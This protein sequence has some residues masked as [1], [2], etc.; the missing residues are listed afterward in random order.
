MLNTPVL[1]LIFNRPDTTDR[2]FDAIRKAQPKQ[3]FVAADGPRFGNVTDV[4]LCNSTKQIID[5]VDWQ[6]EV[7]TLYR[8]TN[9][10]C[11]KA[12][13]EAITWFFNQ[14]E[15]GIVLEDDCLPESTFFQFCET[16][17]IKF[18]D[19]T[20]KAVVCGTNYLY[21]GIKELNDDYFLSRYC[22]V[23]GWA[24]WSRVMK[25]VEW[26]LD[27]LGQICDEK[28]F[29]YLYNENKEVANWLYSMIKLTLDKKID[30][31]DTIFAY[32][33]A[34]SRTKNLY[35]VKNQIS[36]I[37]SNGTHI[38]TSKSADLFMKTYK[39][40]FS[41]DI[42]CVNSSF[43]NNLMYK[44]IGNIHF[45]KLSLHSRFIN[46]ICRVFKGLVGFLYK[47]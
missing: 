8:T 7:K 37:G 13:S 30:T 41:N 18:K 6:C 2:V 36:N 40:V 12:V 45:Q 33:L 9:L 23:W 32:N 11:G 25:N 31:W 17:L 22:I 42:N 28:K 44:N 1:F 16:M 46:K 20:S 5:K 34:L 4:E 19:D 43:Y 47:L 15:Y 39:I 10:G 35:P 27:K 21:S 29:E 3:L 26:D 14:V 38:N 24:S